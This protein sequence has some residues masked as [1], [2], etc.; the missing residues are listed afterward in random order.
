MRTIKQG[1]KPEEKKYIGTCGTC[2]GKYE[3]QQSELET[4]YDP[5]DQVDLWSAKC[6]CCGHTVYFY[7]VKQKR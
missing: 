2:A 1:V 4:V 7:A 3:A 5:K 6:P